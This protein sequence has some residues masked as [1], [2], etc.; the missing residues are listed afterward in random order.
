MSARPSPLRAAGLLALIG[1]NAW[2]VL[3]LLQDRGLDDQLV[4]GT[5]GWAPKL[6]NTIDGL[7]PAKPI[8]AYG[9][10]LTHPVF[11][12]TREP[13]VPPPAVPPPSAVVPVPS[14]PAVIDPGLTLGGVMMAGDLKKAYLRTRATPTG[15]WVSEGEEFMGWKVQSIGAAAVKLQ[16]RDR[17]VELELYGP[18]R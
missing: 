15:T 10:T 7:P 8:S 4:T 9:Q 1:L 17:I 11:F 5:T 12:K 16:Q 6:S 2:L 14:S 18:S 3:V 13:Y